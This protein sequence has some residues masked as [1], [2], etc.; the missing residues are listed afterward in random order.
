MNQLKVIYQQCVKKFIFP[1][2]YDLLLDII[3]SSFNIPKEN[4]IFNG[5]HKI[6]QDSI[7]DDN[8]FFMNFF[9]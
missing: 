6:Y 3:T 5:V 9:K 4:L 2:T 8:N 1:E 7:K